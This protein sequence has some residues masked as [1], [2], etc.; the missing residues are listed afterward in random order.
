VA[1]VF[2]ALRPDRWVVSPVMASPEEAGEFQKAVHAH[3]AHLSGGG[4]ISVGE[5]TTLFEAAGFV[6]VAARDYGGQI[7][8]LGRRP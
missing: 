6:D 2:R 3:G 1:A 8:M 4:P 7:V 5:A